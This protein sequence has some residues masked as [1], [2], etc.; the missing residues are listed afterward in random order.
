[1][2]KLLKLEAFLRVIELSQICT[3]SHISTNKHLVDDFFRSVDFIIGSLT[4]VTSEYRLAA[5]GTSIFSRRLQKVG[6]KR[7]ISSKIC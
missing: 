7:K 6:H 5:G 4:S 3:F 2:D 1:M